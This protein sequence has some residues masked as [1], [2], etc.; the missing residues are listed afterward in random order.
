MCKMWM[1][2]RKWI[3]T[4][5]LIKIKLQRRM[6]LSKMQKKLKKD[7]KVSIIKKVTKSLRDRKV[8][9]KVEI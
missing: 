7:M 5:I 8:D 2:M 3:G 9:P 4:M 1:R 6:Y